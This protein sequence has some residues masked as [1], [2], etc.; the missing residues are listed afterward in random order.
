MAEGTV[1][2]PLPA[3]V[4]LVAL[5]LLTAL[6]WWRVLN[7]G[8]SHASP[9][10]NCPSTSNVAVLPRPAAVSV[11][12]LNS[13][14]RTGIAKATAAVLASDGFKIT[15]YGN[16]TGTAPVAGVAEIRFSAD[17]QSGATLL[18]YYFPGARMVPLNANS[19]SKLVVAI[20]AKFTQV[21]TAAAAQ[22]AITDAHASQAPVGST[23]V[24]PTP[25]P[26]C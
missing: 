20:G 10:K 6:V 19:D 22:T 1:R 21:A 3:L 5:T 15:T 9:T 8:D 12:V 13:T 26:T 24:P 25:S 7:R 4:C 11:T 23:T 16:D 17:L 18:S 2:R 14:N